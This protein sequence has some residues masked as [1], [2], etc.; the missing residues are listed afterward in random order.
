VAA[1][2]DVP[3]LLL[4]AGKEAGQA[5]GYL[6]DGSMVVVEGGRPRLGQEVGSRHQRAHHRQRPAGL[7]PARRR[8][9]LA[10]AAV[11]RPVPAPRRRRSRRARDRPAAPRP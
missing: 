5:V 3:V 2:D 7:R 8:G 11:D 9:P 4:K 1:G 6:D 10:R